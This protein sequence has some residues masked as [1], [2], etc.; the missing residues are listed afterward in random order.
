MRPKGRKTNRDGKGLETENPSV[1]NLETYFH[2]CASL[3]LPLHSTALLSPVT[4][5]G[6][7]RLDIHSLLKE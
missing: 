4:A 6:Y 7:T 5:N 1:K 3:L 2:F